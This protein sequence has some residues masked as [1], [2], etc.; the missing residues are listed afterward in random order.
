MYYLPDAQA[1]E[2]NVLLHSPSDWPKFASLENS[3][4]V[5][6]LHVQGNFDFQKILFFLE[7]MKNMEELTIYRINETYCR[8]STL[9]INKSEIILNRIVSV[10]IVNMGPCP[11][12]YKLLS[13]S[14]RFNVMNSLTIEDGVVNK[15]NVDYIRSILIK[16]KSTLENLHFPLTRWNVKLFE[17][18]SVAFVNVQK[19]HLDFLENEHASS[20][21]CVPNDFAKIFP[22]LGEF[23]SYN[24]FAQWTDLREILNAKNLRSLTLGL[25][26]PSNTRS[27]NLYLEGKRFPLI[28][29]VYLKLHSNNTGSREACKLKDLSLLRR[30]FSR[31][32]ISSNC[33]IMDDNE[34]NVHTFMNY[35]SGN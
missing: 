27:F 30:A 17:H 3:D 25:Q 10:S 1:V 12:L 35:K 14:V 33:R 11:I 23:I 24:G 18:F 8:D 9:D 32:K 4:R 21:S 16:N 26:V 20:L 13:E 28:S 19:I 31:I 6:S 15:D 29:D 7:N 5:R 22:K 2:V 34:F